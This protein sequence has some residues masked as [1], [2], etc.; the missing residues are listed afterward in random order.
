MR[1]VARDL[2][3]KRLLTLRLERRQ[4]DDARRIALEK[5]LGYLTLM[6]VWIQEGIMREARRSVRTVR[7]SKAARPRR[8]VR[9][10]RSRH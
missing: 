10:R 5:G 4:I 1:A 7:S 6:R 3:K 9:S 2:M 8:P